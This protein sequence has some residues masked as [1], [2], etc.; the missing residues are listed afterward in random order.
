[1]DVIPKLQIPGNGGLKKGMGPSLFRLG[2]IER[3][4]AG[5]TSPPLR[6]RWFGATPFAAKWALTGAL[7][8]LLR[9]NPFASIPSP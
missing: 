8:A 4:N 2:P 7:V 9:L 1:M 3:Q 6:G 5:G